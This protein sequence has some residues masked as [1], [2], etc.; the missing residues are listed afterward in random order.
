MSNII[1]NYNNPIDFRLSYDEYWD[2]CPNTDISYDSTINSGLQT[3][4]LISYI[5][6]NN[7]DCVWFDKLY[8]IKDYKWNESINNG[9]ETN[10]I[11]YTGV[12]NGVIEYSKD[13]IS[14]EKFYQLFTNSKLVIESGDMRLMMKKVYGNNMIYDYSSDVVVK[15]DITCLKLN[16]GFYQGF[17]KLSG[18]DYHIL[19]DKLDNGIC[20]EFVV[21]KSEFDKNENNKFPLL[22]G[23]YT[24]NKGIFFYIGTRAENK[25][26]VNYNTEIEKK[27][28][29]NSYFIDGYVNSEYDTDSNDSLNDG[30]FKQYI[31]LYN[32]DGY[33][34][35]TYLS[36][37]EI[38][39]CNNTYFSDGYAKEGYES[40]DC[41]ICNNYSNDGYYKEDKHID[42]KEIIKTSEGYD[43]TQP[44]IFEIKTDNK[45]I[46][47]N[48]TKDGFNVDTWNNNDEYVMSD[49]K[50]PD[51]ENYFMLFNRTKN[52]YNVNSIDALLKDKS[53]KYDV[54]DDIFKNALSFQIKDNGSIGYK[55]LV[56]D[57]ESDTKNYKI[58][59]EFSIDGIICND[60][61]YDIHVKIVPIDND[62]MRIYFYVNG[63][64][65]LISKK[66]PIIELRGLNDLR[67][68]QIGVPYN[69]S[70]GGGT[71][72]LC[73]VIYLNY[74]KL[75]EYVL[76][77]EKEFAGTFIG[78]VKSFKIYNCILNM[79]ELKENINFEKF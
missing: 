51:E 49:I 75:P 21:N 52:G 60:T 20:F 22:N 42:E 73:D 14:N 17:F 26:W 6:I 47:F 18:F 8:S 4:C 53:K 7:P 19:P 1:K 64:L 74:R 57:C 27:K 3:R 69:I 67:D 24:N 40:T 12:D 70:I 66:L 41:N 43:F 30:Y 55:Y 58:E 59:T 63:K 44:N 16:G 78:Y 72:G 77:L 45:F 68:K 56:R 31:N 13:R 71:Q 79:T 2:F 5:D 25:W 37:K 32:R 35:D 11:G 33:F 50:I 23:R 54:L 29:N 48:R 61:W 39:G 62:N 65:C 15:D 46:F 76:P 34:S 28:S 38:S 10:Y 9:V 36:D